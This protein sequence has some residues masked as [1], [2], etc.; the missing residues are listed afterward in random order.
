MATLI[1][2]GA[3]FIGSRLAR[4]LLAQNEEIVILDNL[5]SYY[6][7]AIK[8]ANLTELGENANFIEGDI[9]DRE[10]VDMI[11]GQFPIT[12]VAHMA[13]MSNV[14]YS[15]ERGLLYAEVNTNG[16]VI[17]LDTARKHDVS[18][19][20]MGSTS[21]V[22]GHAARVPFVEDD[23]ADHPLAPYPASKRAAELFGYSYHQLFG[24]N[25]T[26]LRFFN[27]YGPNG[28]PDMMPMRV[29]DS[30]LNE[31]TIEKFDGGTLQ[32][33]WTYIDDILDGIIA[34][35]ERPLGYQIINLGC[36]APITLNEFIRI[37]EHLIEKEAV[38]V[39][40]PTPLTEPRITYCDNRRARESLGFSPKVG[41][42]EGLARTWA[43]Y[44]AR[45]LDG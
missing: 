20:V 8:Q 37:F 34:A 23:A 43:W 25:V 18:V 6:D 11:F 45:Y 4:R 10:Q 27:V 40:V 26:V 7:P 30:I 28:R 39:D 5:D 32:R 31:K 38:T 14:R 33:D 9:R 19:F 15:A 3:G 41:I 24:L 22:Y 35:L 13:A 42:E 12:R 21:S 16:S 36:G 2:G 29:I 1:T 44:R 17:L